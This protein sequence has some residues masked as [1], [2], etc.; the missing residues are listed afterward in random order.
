M[1]ASSLQRDDQ[2]A[3]L[4]ERKRW[5]KVDR[6]APDGLMGGHHVRSEAVP[7][8]STGNCARCAARRSF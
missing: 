3:R 1:N 5:V 2:R 6:R 7:C 4:S 8:I